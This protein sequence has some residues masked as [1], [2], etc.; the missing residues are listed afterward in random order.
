MGTGTESA[1]IRRRVVGE[2]ATICRNWGKWKCRT[3][4]NGLIN[5]NSGRKESL[6]EKDNQAKNDPFNG[7]SVLGTGTRKKTPET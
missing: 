6:G 4:G 3:G 5:E 7:L 1:L 2:R